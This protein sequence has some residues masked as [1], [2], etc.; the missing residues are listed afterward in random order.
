MSLIIILELLFHDIWMYNS[1][2]LYC[3]L[4]DGKTSLLY[5]QLKPIFPNRKITGRAG[6]CLFKS[7][8]AN[9]NQRGGY[10]KWDTYSAQTPNK[11]M[12]IYSRFLLTVF[13]G[14]KQPEYAARRLQTFWAMVLS[15]EPQ[16]PNFELT[17]PELVVAS[18][19]LY[20]VAVRTPL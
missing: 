9:P 8:I 20:K 1:F 16:F 2:S 5:I 17:S 13:R 18:Y 6:S 11:S 19:Q 4:A 12:R 15:F 14:V 3:W 7:P 10:G